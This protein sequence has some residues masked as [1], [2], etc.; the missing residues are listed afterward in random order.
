MGYKRTGRPPYR[1]SNHTEEQ[2]AT[3]KELLEDGCSYRETAHTTKIPRTTL[4]E[5]LPGYGM[6]PQEGG[7]MLSVIR[8]HQSTFDSVLYEPGKR[9][10]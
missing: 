10:Y 5:N 7:Q 6:T 1:P 2:W 9:Q 3:A 8:K 4:R